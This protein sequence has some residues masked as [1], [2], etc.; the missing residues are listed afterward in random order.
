M[1]NLPYSNFWCGLCLLTKPK[2]LSDSNPSYRHTLFYKARLTPPGKFSVVCRCTSP[3]LPPVVVS[4]GQHYLCTHYS[5]L[6]QSVPP[7]LLWPG[8]LK[9]SLPAGSQSMSWGRSPLLH[10]PIPAHCPGVE[11]RV[12]CCT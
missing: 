11:A 6:L 4:L 5:Q 12:L 2:G 3:L 10:L 7:S 9:V 8:A 1:W